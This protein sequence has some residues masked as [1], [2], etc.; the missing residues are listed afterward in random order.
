MKRSNVFQSLLLAG[1]VTVLMVLGCGKK[2]EPQPEETTTTTQEQTQ[3]VEQPASR[4]FAIT[5]PAS[6]S[7]VNRDIITVHGTGAQP[8]TTVEIDVFTDTWYTQNGAAEI[9]GDGTWSY[10]P[11]YL[12]GQGSFK[13]NHNIRAR[14]MSNEQQVAV[15]T[16]YDVGVE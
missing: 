11:C 3:P 1:V 4:E 5:Y 13:L 15:V 14:L 8:G 2:S 12:K 10:S 16:V 9:R 6:N 7:K